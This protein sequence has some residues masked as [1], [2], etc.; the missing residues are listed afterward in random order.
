MWYFDYNERFE[1]RTI[2]MFLL[3]FFIQSHSFRI[4]IDKKVKSDRINDN[5]NQCRGGVIYD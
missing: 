5:D 3:F 4:T 2:E 1:K